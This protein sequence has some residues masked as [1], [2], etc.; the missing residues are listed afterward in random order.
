[1]NIR[2]AKA[3]DARAIAE[4]HVKTWQEAY[5]GVLRKDYLDGLNV[6]AYTEQWKAT[7]L[8]M[9]EEIENLVA[10]ED[11]RVIG[12]AGFGPNHDYPLG[13]EVGE[14]ITL[15]V[16]PSRWGQGTGSALL[17]AA[18]Q[19]LIEAGFE[20]AILW[21]IDT[22]RI[23]AFFDK[24]GWAPDGETRPHRAG[25][26]MVRFFR[27]FDLSNRDLTPAGSGGAANS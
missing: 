2:P 4:V 14:V 16:E 12:F 18:E 22:E 15:Y 6:D 11:G 20:S 10:E 21:A 13:D 19:R 9:H 27:K 24:R 26:M 3:A 8:L 7:I 5:A 25:P 17:T 1:M 23:R